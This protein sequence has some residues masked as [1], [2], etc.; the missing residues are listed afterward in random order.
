MAFPEGFHAGMSLAHLH[1]RQVGY[2]SAACQAQ[3]AR[4]AAMGV[5][6]VALTPFAYV[7]GTDSAAFR[8][9]EGLDRTLTDADLL[10]TCRQAHELGLQVCLKPHVW[11]NAFWGGGGSRQDMRAPDGDWDAWFAGY[12]GFAVH[13]ARL[14]EQARV[15]LYVV[16]LEY[17]QASL[18]GGGRWAAVASACR[19]VYGG[20]LTY[21]ANWWKEAERFGDW[22]SFDYVG[23]NAYHELAVPDAPTV[24]ELVRAWARPMDSL[25]ALGRKA[26]KPVLLTEVGLRAVRGAAAE[27]WKQSGGGAADP[28]LQGRFY[29]AV[30][31]AVAE[32]PGI[33]GIYWWKWFTD[34]ERREEDDYVPGDPAQQVLR[35]W[36]G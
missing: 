34:W 9:G 36:W 33:A 5:K 8:Y 20:A 7:R 4:L 29:E 35:S 1:S 15:A 24:D 32:R 12:T 31:R 28:D 6:H 3:L 14:A 10:E 16:G 23:V 26:Q 21:A 30:L 19:E 11:S 13:Y 18:A 25:V 27:P 17:L 2:G 22:A